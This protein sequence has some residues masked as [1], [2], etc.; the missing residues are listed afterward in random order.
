MQAFNLTCITKKIGMKVFKQHSKAQ[1]GSLQASN[2]CVS[3]DVMH[4]HIYILKRI[5]ELGGF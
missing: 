5:I 3:S 4:T 1:V 2:S